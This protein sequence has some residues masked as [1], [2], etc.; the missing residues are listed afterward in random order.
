MTITNVYGTS[1]QYFTIGDITIYTGVSPFAYPDIPNLGNEGDIFL[2]NDGTKYSKKD[3]QWQILITQFSGIT[4]PENTLGDN[5]DLYRL[6]SSN[7][8]TGIKYV[9]L[10]DSTVSPAGIK[11]LPVTKELYANVPNNELFNDL[12]LYTISNQKYVKI[13]GQWVES[14]S[15]F[16]GTTLPPARLG[17]NGDLYY[18]TSNSK[19]Y[20]KVNGDWLSVDTVYNASTEPPF[21]DY[22]QNEDIWIGTGLDVV[23][24]K[25]NNIWVNKTTAGQVFGA[26]G[27]IS[28]N[29]FSDK[30]IFEAIQ[31][32]Y[33]AKI[34]GNWILT[35][36]FYRLP[37]NPEIFVGAEN[38]TCYNYN[39]DAYFVKT[40][41]GWE[42]MNFIN[43]SSTIPSDTQ[44]NDNDITYVE[45]KSYSIIANNAVTPAEFNNYLTLPQNSDG[46]ANDLYII[47]ETNSTYFKNNIGWNLASAVNDYT[48]NPQNTA[49][50]V[51]DNY[52]YNM[53]DKSFVN[54][55]GNWKLIMGNVDASTAPTGF[56]ADTNS[57]YKTTTNYYVYT[58]NWIQTVYEDSTTEPQ[59]SSGVNYDIYN[60]P[61]INKRFAKMNSVWVDISSNAELTG[62]TE[63]ATSIGD[64][65]DLYTNTTTNIKYLKIEIAQWQTVSNEYNSTDTT[66]PLSFWE[67]NSI[68]KNTA[69]EYYIKTASGWQLSPSFYETTTLPPVTYWNDYYIFTLGAEK[70]V[71]YSNAWNLIAGEINSTDEP[72]INM[73]NANTIY[74]TG[75]KKYIKTEENTWVTVNIEYNSNNK[76][77]NSF[78]NN[79]SIYQTSNNLYIKLNNIW[80]TATDMIN[81]N[82]PPNINYGLDGDIFITSNY[83]FYLKTNNIWRNITNIFTG[84]TQP[85]YNSFGVNLSMYM[86]INGYKFVKYNDIWNYVNNSLEGSE[87]PY[88]DTGTIGSIFMLLPDNI[89]Y[90]LYNDYTW[91]LIGNQYTPASNP[92]DSQGQYLWLYI[93]SETDMMFYN[94]TNWISASGIIKSQSEP[95]PSD[96][97][98]NNIWI[99]L[100]SGLYVK[101]NGV[102]GKVITS[103]N[104]KYD[105][106]QEIYLFS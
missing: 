66:P 73:W 79:D 23:Y 31:R 84:N 106:R 71:R 33:Y 59:I 40:T 72:N 37:Q 7:G 103:T 2:A 87:P 42:E 28:V 102:W 43:A 80:E 17:V 12:D 68:F 74:N 9:K 83:Q 38:D 98:V 27:K 14:T 61:N 24:S 94:G 77:D 47:N 50:S 22:G 11:W 1:S 10:N 69:G 81:N 53:S 30:T 8:I 104:N 101:N 16:S 25:E 75:T 105:I 55:A 34:N 100:S 36:M 4:L 26:N 5:G 15:D 6:L 99:L 64:I 57:I 19:Y 45:N 35:N 63:P 62:T 13:E 82:T 92:L 32:R 65:G 20:Y 67:L 3:G 96:G 93:K 39:T 88:N 46:V 18:N 97:V 29:Y 54:E 56:V 91:R 90:V 86:L 85:K 52:L 44:G 48:T 95:T 49:A 89:L 51:I 60:M 70:Y 41:S 78:W 21:A 76:P 58:T